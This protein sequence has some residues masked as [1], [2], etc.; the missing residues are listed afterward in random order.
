MAEIE[1]VGKSLVGDMPY[2]QAELT[3]AIRDGNKVSTRVIRFAEPQHLDEAVIKAHIEELLLNDRALAE[4]A[5]TLPGTKQTVPGTAFA[6]EVLDAQLMGLP[7]AM[8]LRVIVQVTGP[9]NYQLDWQLQE[10]NEVAE[11][12][13][14]IEQTVK[15][16]AELMTKFSEL[17]TGVA[18]T[19]DRVE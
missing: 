14:R 5:K 17:R 2:A 4:A 1:I 12:P 7:T 3:V 16:S 9:A 6:W 13:K 8:E 11:L 18:L 19:L 15:Q 10:A